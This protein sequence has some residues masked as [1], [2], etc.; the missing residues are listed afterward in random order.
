MNNLKQGILEI[1]KD[2]IAPNLNLSEV[3]MKFNKDDIEIMKIDDVTTVVGILS[4]T[5]IGTK[6]FRVEIFFKNEIIWSIDL[7][8]DDP[9]IDEPIMNE[10]DFWRYV[11]EQREWLIEELGKS[12]GIRDDITF[13]WGKI[14]PW[15]DSRSFGAGISIIYFQK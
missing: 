6:N 1:N 11:A 2:L 15:F 9:E 12:D 14:G 7:R 3:I 10:H 8:I 4:P 13:E 5:K